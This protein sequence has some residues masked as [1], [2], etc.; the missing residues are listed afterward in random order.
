M[1]AALAAKDL[2]CRRGDRLLFAGLDFALEAGSALHVTG[3]NGTGKSSLIRILA[4]LLRPYAGAVESHGSMG[5]ID[6]RLALDPDW[7]LARALQFWERLDG[8]GDPSGPLAVME[9]EPLLDVPVRYL[10]TGQKKRASFARLLCKARDIWLL[11]E[12]FNG[13]DAGACERVEALVALHCGG[14]GICVIASHQPTAIAA[15]SLAI[16]DYE[17]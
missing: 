1:Q 8:C 6:E 9:L 2:A 12:P 17:R 14:G 5:L 11:D 4:G 13:L 3:P 7:P 16:T 15:Q 10:S